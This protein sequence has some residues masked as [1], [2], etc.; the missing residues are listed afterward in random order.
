MIRTWDYFYNSGGWDDYPPQNY[1]HQEGLEASVT[2]VVNTAHAIR[3]AKI[4]KMAALAL[5]DP[6]SLQ[7]IIE[8]DEDIA[9]LSE[10]LHTYAWDKSSGYFGYVCQNADGQYDGI[11]R[12]E[13]D[14]NLNMGLDGVSP[15]VAGICT[16]EQEANLLTHLMS[17]QHLWTPCGLSTVDRSAAY[18]RDDGYWNG[19]VWM[20]HQWLI[21]KALLDLGKTEEAYRIANTA[22]TL[23][24]SEVEASHNCYEHFMIETGRG[25]GWYHFGGLSAPVVN[26]YSAYY[27]PGNMSTGFDVWVDKLHFSEE[28]QALSAEL[29]VNTQPHNSP[30]LIVTLNENYRYAVYWEDQAIEFHQRHPGVLEIHLPESGLASDHLKIAPL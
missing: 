2:P 7:D 26:W 29:T 9:V 1:V 12:D 25:A 20:S 22:L 28:N 17:E 4:L 13:S 6:Q 11:L 18:Y 3:T 30:A 10:A 5:G 8:Y 16:P 14:K 27:R 24:Q 15:L 23:W 21:W 19:A